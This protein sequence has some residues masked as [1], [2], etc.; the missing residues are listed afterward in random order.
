MS[1]LQFP[2]RYYHCIWISFW[3]S[4]HPAGRSNDPIRMTP[5]MYKS[6]PLF[7][8][9]PLRDAER[10]TRAVGRSVLAEMLDKVD[11]SDV[12]EDVLNALI[13]ANESFSSGQQISELT[14]GFSNQLTQIIPG[15]QSLIKLLVTDN[16]PENIRKNF[17]LGFQKSPIHKLYDLNRFGTGLQNLALVAIFRQRISSSTSNTPILA[18]EEPE[19]HLHPHAQR[20]LF[21]DIDNINAPVIIT[22][23]SP[24]LVKYADPLGIILLRSNNDISASFQLDKN[25][26][27]SDE[28]KDL[29]L[30]MRNGRA[31]LFFA[32]SIIIVEGQSE[33]ISFP[34]FSE[35]LGCDFD[36]DGISIISAEGNNFAFILKCCG[37]ENFSIPSIVVYDMDSIYNDNS[38]I[39][40][41]YKANL[42]D[43]YTKNSIDKGNEEQR[44]VNR[45][46]ILDKLGWFGADECFEEVVCK[47]GYQQIVVDAIRNNDPENHSDQKALECFLKDNGYDLNPKSIAKFIKKRDNLKIPIAKAIYEA[48]VNIDSVPLAYERAIRQAVLLSQQGIVVDEFFEIRTWVAGFKNLLINFLLENNLFSKYETFCNNEGNTLPPPQQYQ[49]FIKNCGLPNIRNELK[50]KVAIAVTEC[51]CTDFGK[52]IHEQNFS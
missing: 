34:A 22:T 2:S 13:Q 30:L 43:I 45:K 6:L 29:E 51:G 14:Q 39:K 8:L 27:G 44:K 7:F 28:I 5:R 32:R 9:G 38:L 52:T 50:N 11:Y 23:H 35:I 16:N 47:E 17:H 19:A 31:E 37:Q 49:E 4:G 24:S 46:T 25:K 21:K 33:I 26:V 36:R 48:V 1:N 42:I 15:G 40:V 12:Q 20:R 3:G 18:I 41:A 10:D